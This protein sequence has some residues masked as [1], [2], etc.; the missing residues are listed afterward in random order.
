MNLLRS[1]LSKLGASSA[2]LAKSA[3]LAATVLGGSLL[4]GGEAKA[5]SFYECTFGTASATCSDDP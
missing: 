1:P 5:Q 4:A 3:L 2:G